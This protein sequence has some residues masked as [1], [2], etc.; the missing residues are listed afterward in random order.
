MKLHEDYKYLTD[1]EF[2]E[3]KLGAGQSTFAKK[4]TQDD[5]ELSLI[6]GYA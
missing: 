4:V 3:V 2:K 1:E 5:E 6:Q